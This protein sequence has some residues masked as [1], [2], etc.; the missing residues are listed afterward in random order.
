VSDTH[1]HIDVAS[2]RIGMCAMQVVETVQVTPPSSKYHHHTAMK[3]L[4]IVILRF[5]TVRQKM[6]L[7]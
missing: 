6:V 5:G 3:K 2:Q 4:R 7:E 1:G